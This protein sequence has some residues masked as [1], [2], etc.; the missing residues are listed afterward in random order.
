MSVE[1]KNKQTIFCGNCGRKGHKHKACFNPKISLGLICFKYDNLNIDKQLKHKFNN[2]T[3][4]NYHN[5]FNT[6]I[7]YLLVRRKNS[8]SYMEYIRGKYNLRNIN[9]IFQMFINMT[10]DEVNNILNIDFETLWLQLWSIN[11]NTVHSHH[12][13]FNEAKEKHMILVN[14]YI[15]F[16]QKKKIILSLE[17]IVNNT[18]TIYTEPEWGFPKGR[19]NLRESDINCAHREFVEETNFNRTDYN[20]INKYPINEVFTGSNN[21]RYKHIYFIAQSITNIIPAVDENNFHQRI[22]IGDIKWFTYDEA[23]DKI[24]AYNYEKRKVLTQ[25]NTF[26]KQTIIPIQLIDD[27]SSDTIS[28]NSIQLSD[29][30]LSDND[31]LSTSIK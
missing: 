17:Y 16:H 28:D 12:I 22:E 24:R 15:Y 6:E 31:S 2:N 5:E 20:I 18:T 29:M 30:S 4:I 1:L 25:V 11:N 3:N 7:K 26:I 10:Q 13:E 9:Y 21:I 14:G 27:N 8:L 23:C 19:R